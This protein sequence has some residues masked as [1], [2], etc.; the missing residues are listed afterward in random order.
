MTAPIDET[1]R[2]VP[3]HVDG[4]GDVYVRVEPGRIVFVTGAGTTVDV[5]LSRVAGLA[6][7][8]ADD[9]L[10]LTLHLAN[11]GLLRVVSS[12]AP[13][14]VV[15]GQ[16][17]GDAFALPELMRDMRV[18]GAARALPGSEHDRFFAPLVA[19]LRALRA[20]HA[21]GAGGAIA[22]P[23]RSA[24]S[25]G[26]TRAGAE[27]RATLS[28]IA[29]ERFPVSAPDRRALEA[30]LLDESEPLFDALDVLTV[31]AQKLGVASERD[32]V[33]AWR[34]WCAALAAT[35]VAADRAWAAVLPALGEAPR[36]EPGRWRAARRD[37]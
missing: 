34:A 8:R 31:A 15:V 16:V 10:T 28:A 7:V 22:T 19:P 25:V 32:R 26:A 11:G 36:P 5:P 37:G 30:E 9:A 35:F 6:V 2:G 29:A 18:Y 24:E 1:D 4:R 14:D 23:W 12:A 27:I 33:A 20:A 17:V 21:T 3:A 13:F